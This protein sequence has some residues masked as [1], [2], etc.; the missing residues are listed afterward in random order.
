MADFVSL[1]A[2]VRQRYRGRWYSSGAKFQAS[3]RD[4]AD[5]IAIHFAVKAPEEEAPRP[6]WRRYERRDMKPRR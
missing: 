3:V 5:L 2:T 1:I 6:E 4:A